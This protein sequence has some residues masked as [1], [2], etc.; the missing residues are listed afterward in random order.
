MTQ[1]TNAKKDATVAPEEEQKITSEQQGAKDQWT[2]EC[3]VDELF[4]NLCD[5]KETITN[6]NGRSITVRKYPREARELM[7]W[8]PIVRLVLNEFVVNV[9]DLTPRIRQEL[10]SISKTPSTLRYVLT[11]AVGRIFENLDFEYYHMSIARS[12]RVK[13]EA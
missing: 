9:S 6:N 5:T 3:M 2:T 1:E 10:K 13:L 11:Q 12:L 4:L 7:K 8:I